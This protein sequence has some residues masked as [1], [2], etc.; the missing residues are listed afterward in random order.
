[1]IARS[2][3]IVVTGGSVKIMVFVVDA[4]IKNPDGEKCMCW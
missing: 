4:V 3:K 1:M 2:V